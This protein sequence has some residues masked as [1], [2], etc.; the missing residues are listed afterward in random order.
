ME[1]FSFH[2]KSEILDEI[3]SRPKAD[4]CLLG[5]LYTCK[6]ISPEGVLFV[7]ENEKTMQFFVRS[8][9]KICEDEN[10]VSVLENKKT[11][12]TVFT[13]EVN[14]TNAKKLFS[15]YKLPYDYAENNFEKA[16][17]P[18]KKLLPQL[19]GGAFISCGSIS[20]PNKDYHFELVFQN[21]ALCNFFGLLIIEN[22]GI[23]PKQTE[24]KN[25]QVVYIKESENIEDMLTLMGAVNSSLEIM[26][27]KIL[28]DIRNK[29]NRAVNCDNA[30]IEKTLRASEKQIEDIELIESTI[31]FGEL[32]EDLREIAELR[33]E[34]PDY[35]LKEL[36][37]ALSK[38]ISRSGANHRLA[39][40]S[41]I[42][43]DIRKKQGN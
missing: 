12:S 42:A 22:Y 7:T 16:V 38:P 35:N 8:I 14:E 36:G 13:A 40:I 33:L 2:V 18:K 37:Q 21:I 4:A 27:I 10:A 6:E 5:M 24:R 31:G 43:E 19:F 28:K 1:S 25:S 29:I 15:Y 11:K 41:K 9:N 23:I 17:L 32:S 30:N 39:R 3:N 26:N 34:N 20:D